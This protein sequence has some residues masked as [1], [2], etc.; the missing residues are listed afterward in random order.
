MKIHMV[1]K[2]DTLYFIA[3]KYNVS[4]EEILKLNPGITNPDAIDVGMKLK[5]PSSHTGGSGGMDIMHQHVVKQGDTLWKLSKAWGVPLADMIK[6][7]PQ[8]KNPNVLLTGEIVNIPKVG[9]VMPE[10]PAAPGTA[11]AHSLHPSSIMQ[12]VQGWVGKMATAPILGKKPTGPIAGKAPTA[13]ITPL[14]EAAPAAP[15]TPPQAAPI[16]EKKPTAPIVKPVAPAAIP[17]PKPMAIE[18]AKKTLPIQKP[19]E[20]KLAP[21]HAEYKPNVDLFKQY[22]IPATEALSLY[23]LPKAPET[24]SPAAKHPTYGGY[25]YGQPMTMPAQTGHGYGYGYG[26]WHQPVPFSNT[27]SPLGEGHES[28]DCPPGTVFVGSYPSP[29]TMPLGAGP[30]WGYGNPMVSPLQQGFGENNNMVAGAYAMPN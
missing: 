6:A 20:K 28:Y 17:A 24:V 21:I 16:Q 14:A 5:I 18:P 8:L 25:D 13:P 2:G 30:D 27:V 12:N 15:I 19:V 3:Q 29:S 10:A 4:L 23:D 11:G 22:G 7:N 1:K 9:G 26:G